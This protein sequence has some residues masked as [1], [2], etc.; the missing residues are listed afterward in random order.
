MNKEG[1]TKSNFSPFL[2]FFKA[3][4]PLSPTSTFWMLIFWGGRPESVSHFCRAEA[5]SKESMSQP[6]GIFWV[7]VA[8]VLSVVE[9][10]HWIGCLRKFRGCDWNVWLFWCGQKLGMRVVCKI[11][12]ASAMATQGHQVYEGTL[13]ERFILFRLWSILQLWNARLG[14]VWK[15]NLLQ[16]GSVWT[17]SAHC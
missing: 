13:S 6:Q 5:F 15:M 14:L 2:I 9:I 7:T 10:E 16:N 1:G 8:L 4:R 11:L 17:W 3:T 12:E